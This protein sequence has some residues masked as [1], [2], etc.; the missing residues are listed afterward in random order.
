MLSIDL[1]HDF[2]YL[3][4]P[5]L[6]QNKHMFS[7]TKKSTTPLTIEKKKNKYGITLKFFQSVKWCI[8]AGIRTTFVMIYVNSM[9]FSV[10]SEPVFAK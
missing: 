8:L 9:N 10:A 6:E 2:F 5:F 3:F 7:N 1:S 4:I